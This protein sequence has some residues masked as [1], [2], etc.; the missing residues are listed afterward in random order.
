[1]TSAHWEGWQIYDGKKGKDKEGE[2]KKEKEEEAPSFSF[3]I[4]P[5]SSAGKGGTHS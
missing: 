2:E 3:L 1:V 4:I 5:F